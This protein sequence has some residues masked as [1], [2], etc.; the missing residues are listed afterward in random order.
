MKFSK[1]ADLIG[2][3][4]EKGFLFLMRV[5]RQW[6]PVADAVKTQGRIIVTHDSP[7]SQSQTMKIAI[8]DAGKQLKYTRKGKP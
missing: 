3:V 2:D 7:T 5:R 8:N 6:N 1:S 4:L